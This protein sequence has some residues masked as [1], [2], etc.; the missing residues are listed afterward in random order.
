VPAEQSQRL[1]A[2]AHD[3]KRLVL[4]PGADHNDLELLAGPRMMDEI[5][6]FFNAGTNTR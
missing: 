5:A 4:I 1:F 2:A 6:A 3:P